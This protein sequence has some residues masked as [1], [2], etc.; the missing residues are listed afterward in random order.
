MIQSWPWKFVTNALVASAVT[1]QSP[2]PP[3]LGTAT[4]PRTVLASASNTT[5]RP[6][7]LSATTP[8]VAAPEFT[9]R[10]RLIAL[11]STASRKRLRCTLDF[12]MTE[13]LRGVGGPV[14]APQGASVDTNRSREASGTQGV[15][16]GDEAGKAATAN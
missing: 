12:D 10:A 5:T 4:L 2:V 13:V 1:T 11:A 14:R 3:M 16:T 7:P 8:R 9:G 6:E 15:G